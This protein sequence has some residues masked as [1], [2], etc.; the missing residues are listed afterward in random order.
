MNC[1]IYYCLI[2]NCLISTQKTRKDSIYIQ[3]IDISTTSFAILILFGNDHE[4]VFDFVDGETSKFGIFS[5]NDTN[6]N[7]FLL[8]IS[9]KD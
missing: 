3:Y 1:L 4:V 8:K 9:G 5:G 2:Y 7:V 6:F